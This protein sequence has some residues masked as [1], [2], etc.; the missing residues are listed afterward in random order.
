MKI[1][2]EKEEID[3]ILKTNIAEWHHLTDIL[4]E[5]SLDII[6]KE[7]SLTIKNIN[8]ILKTGTIISICD[9]KDIRL[10]IDNNFTTELHKGGTMYTLYELMKGKVESLPHTFLDK[11]IIPP[12]EEDSTNET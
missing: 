8:L 9:Y 3:I 6:R 7:D 1:I 2:I 4:N 12:S 5:I 10:Y 11:E